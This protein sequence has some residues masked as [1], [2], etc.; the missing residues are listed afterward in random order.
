MARSKLKKF[1][2]IEIM[3]N[4]IEPSKAIYTA[5]K[6]NWHTYFGNKNPII[7]ELGCG[8][9]EYTNNLAQIYPN[10]NF[11]GVDIKGERIWQGATDSNN[12]RLTNTAFLRVEIQQLA[13]FFGESEASEIWLT[14][15]DPQPNN[16]K[17]RLTHKFFRDL[18]S[19]I[20]PKNGLIHL[21]TDSDILFDYTIDA[22][23]NDNLCQNLIHTKDLYSSIIYIY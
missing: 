1:R 14:F 17:K 6:G 16:P 8:Y 21:K 23:Q 11:I 20:L 5:I 9:G 15:C 12:L 13:D 10:K 2:E 19:Y 7:L 3:S 4:I 18:Y 22:V